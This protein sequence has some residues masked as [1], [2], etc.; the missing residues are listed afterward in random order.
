MFNESFSWCMALG[1]RPNT[2][3]WLR[4]MILFLL[5]YALMQ[6]FYICCKSTEQN[7]YTF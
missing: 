5:G 4:Y 3:S 7:N 1:T 2:Q 6:I